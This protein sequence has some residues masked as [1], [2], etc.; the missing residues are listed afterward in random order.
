M[1]SKQTIASILIVGGA[2]ATGFIIADQRVPNMIVGEVSFV[3]LDETG[4]ALDC[5]RGYNSVTL[6][7]SPATCK[8]QKCN[9]GFAY[10]G[11][12]DGV[13]SDCAQSFTGEALEECK[14]DAC[15][16]GT[17]QSNVFFESQEATIQRYIA[18]QQEKYIQSMQQNRR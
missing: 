16:N 3:G 14:I 1:K 5:H 17:P 9:G 8:L 6:L 18:E 7:S 2:I 15:L 4:R 10:F 12:N 13:F 11:V